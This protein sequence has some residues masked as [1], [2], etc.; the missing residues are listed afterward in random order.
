MITYLERAIE[1]TV[2]TG[3]TRNVSSRVYFRPLLCD[4]G[5][6]LRLFQVTCLSPDEEHDYKQEDFSNNRRFPSAESCQR[7]CNWLNKHILTQEDP[8]EYSKA[9][10]ARQIAFNAMMGSVTLQDL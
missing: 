7:T 6:G 4:V 10:T 2:K 3:V 1:E 9:W 8:R 5:D